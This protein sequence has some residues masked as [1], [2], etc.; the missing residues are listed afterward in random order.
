M[1]EIDGKT[2]FEVTEKDGQQRIYA[3]WPV[4][5]PAER[6]NDAWLPIA[7][8]QHNVSTAC[9]IVAAAFWKAN[10]L[11]PVDRLQEQVKAAVRALG[12]AQAT[13]AFIGDGQHL[14]RKTIYV[15]DL[16]LDELPTAFR[17]SIFHRIGLPHARGG[18]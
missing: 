8:V 17:R 13:V 11:A 9:M 18:R 5:T 7:E 12:E 4:Y 15:F 3:S 6:M 14:V 1:R 2:V 16:P 10:P